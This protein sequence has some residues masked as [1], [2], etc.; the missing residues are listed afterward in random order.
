MGHKKTEPIPEKCVERN[1]YFFLH[2]QKHQHN[3]RCTFQPSR[4]KTYILPEY[5]KALQRG[6]EC[7]Y[8]E[9]DGPTGKIIKVS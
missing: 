8:Y 9:I 2:R 6:D 1:L 3:F 7:I 4:K 5:A